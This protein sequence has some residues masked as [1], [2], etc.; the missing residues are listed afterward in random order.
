[1]R[2]TESLLK[3]VQTFASEVIC[4]KCGKQMRLAYIIPD[5]PDHDRR[6]FDCVEC[7]HNVT[8]SVQI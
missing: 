7:G 2:G 4:P 1:M 5:T 3:L 8:M 6:T